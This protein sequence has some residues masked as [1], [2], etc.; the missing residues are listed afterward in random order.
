MER[1]EPNLGL[2][3]GQLAL[4]LQ[5]A[6]LPPPG[7]GDFA[8]D[9]EVYRNIIGIYMRHKSRSACLQIAAVA[10]A[11]AF[12]TIAHAE[13][14]REEIVHAYVLLGHANAEY[15]GHKGMAMNELTAAGKLLGLKLE[16]E[17][18]AKERQWKSDERLV[19]AR[20]LLREA[21]T[22]LEAADRDRVAARVDNAIRE[23]DNALK[24]K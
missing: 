12:G 16:G 3:L 13:T 5:S 22:K 18:S 1:C 6:S 15:A 19:E 10:L 4:R 24:I 17:G 11:L 9:A 20:R 8:V 14:P 7:L 23:I 2:A 21:R